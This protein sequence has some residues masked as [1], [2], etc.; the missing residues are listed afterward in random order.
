MGVHR[1]KPGVN[2]PSEHLIMINIL[3][4]LIKMAFCGSCKRVNPEMV[5]EVIRKRILDIQSG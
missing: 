2:T 5:G 1:C 4:L 3:I